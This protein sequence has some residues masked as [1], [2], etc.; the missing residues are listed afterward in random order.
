M[1]GKKRPIKVGWWPCTFD[2]L[3]ERMDWGD[4]WW[5]ASSNLRNRKSNWY[6]WR[7]YAATKKRGGCMPVWVSRSTELKKTLSNKRADTTTRSLWRKNYVFG[8]K[9]DAEDGLTGQ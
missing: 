8:K 9:S 3:Q 5:R 4:G 7:W 6:N 1:R 2:P